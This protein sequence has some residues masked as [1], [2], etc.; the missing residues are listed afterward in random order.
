MESRIFSKKSKKISIGLQK[1][2]PENVEKFEYNYALQKL[3][4]E[5]G[6]A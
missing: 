4:K 5:S 2:I 6:K 1:W 3:K